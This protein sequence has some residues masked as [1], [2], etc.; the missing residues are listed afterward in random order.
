MYLRNFLLLSAVLFGCSCHQVAGQT[1]GCTV[2]DGVVTKVICSG[3][4]D[5]S[6]IQNF[7]RQLAQN[8]TVNFSELNI[9]DNPA[10]Q[11]L[12]DG[13]LGDVKFHQILIVSCPNLVQVDDFLGASSDSLM[14]LSMYY[15]GL[16]EVPQLTAHKLSELHVYQL[17]KQ[18]VVRRTAF[19]GMKDIRVRENCG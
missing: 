6:Q 11:H 14:K 10:I 5:I 16:S 12:P 13:L 15:N 4:I 18:V 9:F 1:P 3:A 8:G 17:E 7:L 19:K 2:E